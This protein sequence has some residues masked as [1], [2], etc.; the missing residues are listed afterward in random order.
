M[1]RPG[2]RTVRI[3]LPLRRCC[4]ARG[5]PSCGSLKRCTKL[6]PR[7]PKRVSKSAKSKPSS[8]WIASRRSGES[9][10]HRKAS[11][12]LPSRHC[13]ICLGFRLLHDAAATGVPIAEGVSGDDAYPAPAADAA[14]TI[15]SN[16]ADCRA[17]KEQVMLWQAYY[18]RLCD[19]RLQVGLRSCSHSV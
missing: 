18:Q 4:Q 11:L 5:R 17:D 6:R 8:M 10:C 12:R 2:L 13:L 7:Q 15:A 1:H 14:S 9:R 16:Y 19:I 3:E